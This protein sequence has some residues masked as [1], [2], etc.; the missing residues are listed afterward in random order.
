VERAGA[1][2]AV[3]VQWHPEDDAQSV[4]EQQRIIDT[5]VAAARG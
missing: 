2:W 3:G 5:F 4:P 1:R